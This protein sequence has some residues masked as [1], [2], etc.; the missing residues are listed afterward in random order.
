MS[1]R[2]KALPAYDG[3]CFII[4]FGEK[5]DEKN[6]IIDGGRCQAVV[7]RLKEEIQMIEKKKQCVDLLVV[8]H[9]DADHI[10]GIL[11]IFEDPDIDKNIFK[12]VWF[13]SKENLSG[14][15]GEGEELDNSL[16]LQ[17]KGTKKIS[18]PQGISFGRLLKDLGFS[19]DKELIYSGMHLKIGQAD[20]KV[21]SPDLDSLKMLYAE[22]DKEFPES[23][24]NGA[25]ISRRS[26]KDYHLEVDVLAQKKFKE[27]TQIVN[28]SSIAFVL[29]YND[30]KILMLGDSH[31]SKVYDGLVKIYNTKKKIKFDLVKVSHHGSKGNTNCELLSLI[32]CKAYLI[33]TNGRTHNLPNK[34]ALS[35]IIMSSKSLIDTTKLYFNYP[36]VYENIFSK[37]EKEIHKFTCENIGNERESYLEV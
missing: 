10:Y 22:W 4:N 36:N 34:E 25:K 2:I 37:S 1:I 23:N 19:H 16:T 24:N 12:K 21:V 7:R 28:G 11:K 17:P 6:I 29:E 15:F 31:P 32:D 26:E 27:D 30:K 3:D 9:L 35:R 18:Y 14:F 13:N 5:G 20:L 8:T 33:S